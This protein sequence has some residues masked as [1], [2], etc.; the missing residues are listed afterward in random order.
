MLSD[1]MSESIFSVTVIDIWNSL[2]DELLRC[3]TVDYFKIKLDFFLKK[4]GIH[5][6]FAFFLMFIVKLKLTNQCKICRF[7]HEISRGFYIFRSFIELLG[8]PDVELFSFAD[9]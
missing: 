9:C 3:R 7:S 8:F 4:T 5:L 2:P 1:M 6:I